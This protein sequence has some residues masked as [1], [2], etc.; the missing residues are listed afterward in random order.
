M[1]RFGKACAFCLLTVAAL[2]FPALEAAAADFVVNTQN[3]DADTNPGDGTAI[4]AGGFTSLRAAIEEVN[5]LAGADTITF[6]VGGFIAPNT[7]FELTDTTGGTSIDADGDINIF[8]NTLPGGAPIFDLQSDGNTIAN[9]DFMAG[10][11]HGMVIQG[12]NNTVRGCKIGTDDVNSFGNGGAGILIQDGE[13]NVIGGASPEDANIIG[14]NTGAGIQ[15]TGGGARNNS[16]IGNLIGVTTGNVPVANVIGIILDAGAFENTIGG[17]TAAERNIISGNTGQGILITGAGTNGNL[18]QGCYIG[19]GSNG[20]LD[21]GNGLDGILINDSASNNDIGAGTPGSGNLISGNNGNGVQIGGAGTDGNDVRG[22]FIGTNDDGTNELPNTGHGILITEGAAGST[23]GGT[24]ADTRNIISGNGNCGVFVD[25]GGTNLVTMLGNYI[26]LSAGGDAIVANSSNG[27]VVTGGA[28]DIVIGGSFAGAGNVVSGNA[29]NGIVLSGSATANVTVA[30]NLIGLD[31]L[32]SSPLGNTSNGIVIEDSASG[33]IVTD[34]NVISGN[35]QAG[36]RLE[37]AISNTISNNFIGT[38]ITGEGNFPNGL[39]GVFLLDSSDNL[40]GGGG[41]GEGNLIVGNAAEGI[42]IDGASSLRNSIRR[43]AVFGNSGTNI[44]LSNGANGGI[45]PPVIS[46]TN[47]VAG[48]TLAN[49]TVDLFA[50]S[51]FIGAKAL[52]ANL[53]LITTVQSDGAGNFAAGLVLQQYAGG[54]LAATVTDAD[55]N[56]SAY[57]IPMNITAGVADTDGDG[58]G[59]DTEAAL[60][61]NP[62]L[63]DTDGDGMADD[64]EV[65]YIPALDPLNPSDAGLDFDEDGITNLRESLRNRDPTDPNSPDRVFFGSSVR[66]DVPEGGGSSTA[67]RTINYAL[68]QTAGLS[69]PVRILLYGGT[70]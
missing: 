42:A 57:S 31:P 53:P 51:S 16:I 20:V 43:N 5:A 48:T 37:D 36:I 60:G 17:A 28:S 12:N 55:G 63:V 34:R 44:L 65:R 24:T 56:T 54:T 30:G 59:D 62:L 40:I 6:S 19:P 7:T 38:D 23:I 52:E 33:M 14:G 11:S 41:F 39:Q 70:Y 18:V 69:G 15:V 1:F 8:A 27:I 9:I 50:S 66:L 32:G 61:T 13:N 26:G 4:T 2:A 35:G 45:A 10:L 58:L 47:P 22:N 29:A 49:S 46:G 67:W 3:D 21:R 25:V 68:Q 64:F